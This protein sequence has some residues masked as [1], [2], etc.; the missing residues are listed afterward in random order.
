MSKV[1]KLENGCWEWLRG[2]RDGQYGV[3][4]IDGRQESA[5]RAAYREFIGPIPAGMLC[6]HTCD[7]PICVNPS[8]LFLG[9]NADN[10]MDMVNKGR[11]LYGERNPKAILTQEKADEI[12]RIYKN[13][14]ITM[15]E[16]GRRFGVS[17]G[18]IQHIIHNRH[19]R[20][21]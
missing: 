10:I 4:K 17:K 9:T 12:R 16:L 19:W 8:H 13:G 6:C 18:C 5:H 21:A 3:I 14:N 20:V 11:Q 15:K 1:N 7:N 2:K